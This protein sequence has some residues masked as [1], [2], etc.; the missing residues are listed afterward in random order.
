M[1]SELSQELSDDA[2]VRLL[3]VL[4]SRELLVEVLGQVQDLLRDVKDLI[5]SHLRNIDE[6]GDHCSID[7]L[8]FLELLTDFEGHVNCTDGEERRIA[9]SKVDVVHRHLGE[10]D[11]HL[12][13]QILLEMG[14]LLGWSSCVLRWLLILRL[15]VFT[16][17]G[18]VWLVWNIVVVGE[19][20]T[21]LFL[22]G[23]SPVKDLNA[24]SVDQVDLEEVEDGW[25]MDFV[26]DG[27]HDVK[28]QGLDSFNLQLLV[29]NFLVDSLHLE[30]VDIFK[31]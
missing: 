4:E 17:L 15:G 5:L 12:L 6:A 13:D 2:E 8:L 22:L 23:L 1:R 11:G 25:S 30:W 29:S 14:L 20:S 18:L 24:K 27:F 10:V 31:F 21:L 3:Q 19:K 16:V 7:Q 26:V 9:D 28:F